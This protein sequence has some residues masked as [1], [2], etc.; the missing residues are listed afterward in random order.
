MELSNYTKD[1]NNNG[2]Q[3]HDSNDREDFVYIICD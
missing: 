2:S 3:P 1:I